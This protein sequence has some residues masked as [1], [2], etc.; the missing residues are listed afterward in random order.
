MFDQ[1]DKQFAASLENPEELERHLAW[2]LRARRF[3]TICALTCGLMFIG[4]QIVGLI[5][6]S[7][8]IH[9]GH[10]LVGVLALVN[11]INA[12]RYHSETRTLLAFKAIKGSAENP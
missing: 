9:P 6:G 7:S 4:F 1:A 5:L 10:V 11:M 12:G 8:T 3:S 2:L